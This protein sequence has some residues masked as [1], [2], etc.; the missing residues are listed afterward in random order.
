MDMNEKLLDENNRVW[1]G[2]R[3]Q[4]KQWDNLKKNIQ[5]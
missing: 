4:K 5:K 1:P 3:E 2:R